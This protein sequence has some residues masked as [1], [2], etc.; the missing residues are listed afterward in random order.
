MI[1]LFWSHVP[2][3]P[4]RMPG[5]RRVIGVLIA[6]LLTA[7]TGVCAYGQ[8]RDAPE[9]RI[10]PADIKVRLGE[11]GPKFSYADVVIEN[12]SIYTVTSMMVSVYLDRSI[13]CTGFWVESETIDCAHPG[14]APH[15]LHFDSRDSTR[16][17]IGPHERVTYRIRLDE[18]AKEK[19]TIGVQLRPTVNWVR[20]DT[21]RSR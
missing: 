4:I 20:A 14:A 19:D 6:L 1:G 12:T 16:G 13:P 7:G 11:V 18:W 2:A 17:G 9:S 15:S 21:T 8:H 3:Q 10:K 5:S